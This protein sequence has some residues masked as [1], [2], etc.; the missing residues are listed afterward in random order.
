MR[1]SEASASCGSALKAATCGPVAP[2]VTRY[3]ESVSPAKRAL[4]PA[5]MSAALPGVWPGVA[6]TRSAP[7]TSSVAPSPYVPT[8]ATAFVRRA[9]R[10]MP[11]SRKPSM[12]G[13]RDTAQAGTGIGHLATGERRVQLVDADRDAVLRADAFG[14]ADV[15]RVPV[16]EDQGADVLDRAPHGRQLAEQVTVVAGHAGVDDRDLA[17]LLDQVA[18]DVVVA[19]AVQG[20]RE[21]HELLLICVVA[22]VSAAARA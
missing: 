4:T 7:G 12:E 3:V 22:V 14:E 6:M 9:P 19:K 21:S 2:L 1:S 17:G 20:R 18:V 13:Q 16:R 11:Q 15:V 5:A 8:S 10:R